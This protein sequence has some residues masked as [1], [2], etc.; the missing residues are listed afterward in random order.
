MCVRA[1]W[2]AVWFIQLFV[3][4][5]FLSTLRGVRAVSFLVVIVSASRITVVDV[6]GRGAESVGI[7]VKQAT[8]EVKCVH[9][10]KKNPLF[11]AYFVSRRNE[12]AVCFLIRGCS[13][14][15]LLLPLDRNASAG[16]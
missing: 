14:L 15:Q 10:K 1:S 13:G 4:V 8:G 5:F 2:R 7:T 6:Q 12:Q 3:C 9:G 11:G 16:E